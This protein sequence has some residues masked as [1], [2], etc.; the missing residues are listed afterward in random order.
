MNPIIIFGEPVP[1]GT[2]ILRIWVDTDLRVGFGRFGEVALPCG[3]YLYVGSAMGQKGAASL[4]RRLL[5]HA[6]R[7]AGPPHPI[8]EEMVRW[9]TA[10]NLGQNLQPPAQKRLHWHVDYLLEETAVTL[11]HVLVIR[12]SKR[13]ETT[14]ARRLN[15]DPR[16]FAPAPGLGASDDAGSTHLL[17]IRESMTACQV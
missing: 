1:T 2:Y 7:A 17:G 13:L 14:L 12:S 3:A 5:R 6:T 16:T 4:A 8:R 9:F 15:A 10:V 11:T